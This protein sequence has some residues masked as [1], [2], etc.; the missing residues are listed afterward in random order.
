VSRRT[1]P[2]DVPCVEGVGHDRQVNRRRLLT[3][4][5]VAVGIVLIVHA[6][7][8]GQTGTT[9][10]PLASTDPAVVRQYPQ[11]GELVLRQAAVGIELLP[12]YTGRLQIQGD[13]LAPVVI[14]DDQIFTGTADTTAG[15]EGSPTPRNRVIFQP[16]KGKE[17]ES[18]PPGR[19]CIKATYWKVSEGDTAARTASWCFSVS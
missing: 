15:Q 1:H 14:P 13:G 10:S 5:A 17:I 9:T 19:Q 7:L 4:L 12:D 2:V 8:S 18:F 11:P 3:S 6:F 16:G